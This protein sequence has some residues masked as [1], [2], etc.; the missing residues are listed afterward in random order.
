MLEH[1]N[2]SEVIVT[3]EGKPIIKI[4]PYE[5][6]IDVSKRIGVAEGK[7][8]IPDDFDEPNDKIARMFGMID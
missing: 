6:T 8:V 7:F 4:I 2:E 3:Q 1:K 5:E